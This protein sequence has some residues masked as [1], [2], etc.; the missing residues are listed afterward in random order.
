MEF[1]AVFFTA[2]FALAIA[3]GMI[4]AAWLFG[5]KIK[6]SIKQEPF[7]CG[8]PPAAKPVSYFSNNF[9]RIALLFIV[10][11]I[12]TVFLYPWAVNFRNLSSGAFY[13][14]LVFIAVLALALF[15]AIKRGALQWD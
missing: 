9:Y 10:F 6:G 12:E 13:A 2:V 7:E 8:M 5:P 11:D 1:M 3:G 4:I 15:Y 14:G